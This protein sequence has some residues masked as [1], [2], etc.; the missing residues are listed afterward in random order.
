MADKEQKKDN[1]ELVHKFVDLFGIKIT[2]ADKGIGGKGLEPPTEEQLEKLF[3]TM[4]K[5]SQEES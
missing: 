4:R 2:A 5:K 1:T 3:E